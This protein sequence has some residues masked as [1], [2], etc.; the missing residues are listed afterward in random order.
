M[1]I[2]VGGPISDLIVAI[3]RDLGEIAYRTTT[4]NRRIQGHPLMIEGPQVRRVPEV[5]C[6]KLNIPC[7]L[8]LVHDRCNE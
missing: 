3:F 4:L 2:T 8:S 6:G 5:V 1:S 7:F